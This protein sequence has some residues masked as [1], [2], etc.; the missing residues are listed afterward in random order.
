[1]GNL[2]LLIVTF[3]CARVLV[4][5]NIFAHHLISAIDTSSKPEILIISLQ[6][7]APIAY[8]FLGGSY[9][10]PY[11]EA[12]CQAVDLAAQ[13]FGTV[14]YGNMFRKNVGMTSLIGFIVED[15]MNCIRWLETGEVGVGVQEMGNK[16]AVGVRI[17][18]AVENETTEM[19]FVGIHGS[20]GSCSGTKKSRLEAYS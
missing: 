12:V 20:R 14:R 18:Y 3:N 1:M 10:A 19:A 7:I 8:A 5:P 13:S 17:G 11:F 2:K 6:E 16:G 15:H 9:L 4:K